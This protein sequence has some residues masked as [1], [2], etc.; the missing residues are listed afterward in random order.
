MRGRRKTFVGVVT[1]N[2]M[3]KTV[4]VKTSR[5]I[6]HKRYGKVVKVHRKFYAH[7][8]SD[9]C[10]IGDQVTIVETRP[11]SKLKKW[12]VAEQSETSGEEK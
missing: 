8:E 7:D 3:N 5:T 4:V 1:S 10:K 11:L 12:R 2:K 9:N 6:R